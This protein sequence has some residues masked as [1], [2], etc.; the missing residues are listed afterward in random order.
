MYAVDLWQEKPLV[1][2]RR[3]SIV[4]MEQQLMSLPETVKRD[5]T[6]KDHFADG[7]YV[8]EIFIPEGTILT[9]KIHK[10]EHINIITQGEVWVATEQTG[11][12]LITAP[13]TYVSPVG[14]KKA[15]FTL[16]DT[17][18]MTVHPTDTQDLDEIEDRIIAQTYDDYLE[19]VLLLEEKK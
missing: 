14:S 1:V 15:L 11:R 3:E 18:W 13:H 10:T 8:R 16:S 6:H 2:K 17:I 5:L 9:G 7:V 12:E 4:R 19:H